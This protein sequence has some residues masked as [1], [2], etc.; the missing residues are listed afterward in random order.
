M[1]SS[2]TM[3]P[4]T[5]QHSTAMPSTHS[6]TWPSTGSRQ[7]SSRCHAPSLPAVRARPRFSAFSRISAGKQN[8]WISAQPALAYNYRQALPA[9]QNDGYACFEILGIDVMMDRD[10]KPWLIEINTSCVPIDAPCRQCLRHGDPI[11]ANKG[12]VGR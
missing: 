8:T 12:L 3:I 1:P 11:H 9:E 6:S 5:A 2:P 7:R 4:R 10:L